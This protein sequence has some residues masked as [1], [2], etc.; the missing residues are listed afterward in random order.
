MDFLP[1]QFA[2]V[3][4]NS[5][6]NKKIDDICWHWPAK[7]EKTSQLSRSKIANECAIAADIEWSFVERD[8]LVTPHPNKPTAFVFTRDHADDPRALPRV[9]AE[10]EVH[11]PQFAKREHSLAPT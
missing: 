5:M 6:L 11:A 9:A 7:F 2:P 1:E 8:K 3:G 10:F 4:L